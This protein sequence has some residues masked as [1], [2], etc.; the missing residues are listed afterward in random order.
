MKKSEKEFI[1][2]AYLS[3]PMYMKMKN[4]L[5]INIESISGLDE[6]PTITKEE[7]VRMDSIISSNSIPLLYNN[8]PHSIPLSSIP[9]IH[10]HFFNR[11]K[12]RQSSNSRLKM[13]PMPW[14]LNVCLAK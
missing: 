11:K 13:K 8:K 2:Q 5:N 12:F 6:L 14:V 7:I 3:V 1:K 10:C 9:V 4:N